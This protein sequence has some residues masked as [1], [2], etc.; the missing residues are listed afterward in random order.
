MCRLSR[1]SLLDITIF[2]EVKKQ[3]YN[4][5]AKYREES[6]KLVYTC[7]HHQVCTKSYA[8]FVCEYKNG[9]GGSTLTGYRVMLSI[10]N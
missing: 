8:T 6:I 2:C 10:V 4:V 7:I 9:N 3:K 1:A 5:K